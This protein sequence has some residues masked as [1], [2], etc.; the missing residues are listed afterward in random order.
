MG[1]LVTLN[2]INVPSNLADPIQGE[3][4]MQRILRHYRKFT[5]LIVLVFAVLL[6]GVPLTAQ[7]E[8]Y[9]ARYEDIPF[10]RTADGGFVLGDPDA[11]VTIVEFADFI[12]PHCQDYQEI[13]HE[14]IDTYVATGMAKF[15]YR[16]FPIVDDTY[17]PLTAQWATC[18]EEQK[19]GA[20]WPAH[21]ALFDLAASGQ[22]DGDSYKVLADIVGVDEDKLNICAETADQH[23]IDTALAGSMGITGTP[24]MMIR[25]EDNTLVWPF[26]E[27]Q[28][29]NR[30]GLP[31]VVLD[32]IVSAEDINEVVL[33]PES[34]LRRL[35]EV[36]L[37]CE[38]PCWNGITPGVTA[39][40]DSV[41]VIE[42]E[43]RFTGIEFSE[44]ETGI[45]WH[46]VDTEYY[47]NLITDDGKVVSQIT[48]IDLSPYTVGEVIEVHGDPLYA[49]GSMLDESQ[50][51]VNLFYP[52]KQMVVRVYVII[53]EEAN[54][55]E[56]SQIVGA[57]FFSE[58]S[59]AGVTESA[60]YV[61]WAGFEGF[62]DYIP[63]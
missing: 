57:F 13:A 44:D 4:N 32:A 63:E 46:P 15:E 62:E 14:F 35:V 55:V 61:E 25:L 36:D 45:R 37:E 16:M 41:E 42:N 38:A 56:G 51:I 26:I 34:I 10:S 52:E 58:E 30:G 12:C 3:N 59:Y 5:P 19:D 40:E 47:S 11:G 27:G 18:A 20:F 54:L 28:L 23:L 29:F 8:G 21:D 22:I 31:M 48:L 7:S 6:S 53:T 50:A 49:L 60:P 2:Y 1:N 9:E 24:G 39:W 33:I 17:S 43:T